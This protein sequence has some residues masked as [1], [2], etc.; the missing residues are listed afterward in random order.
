M[1]I[2]KIKPGSE[3]S[4][5]ALRVGAKISFLE[6]KDYQT[7]AVFFKELVLYS[8]QEKERIDAQKKLGEI[9]FERL[10]DNARAIDE[11]NKVLLIPIEPEEET[12]LR[13]MLAKAYFYLN[14]FGQAESEADIILEKAKQ[15]KS[16]FDAKLVK[17]N[18]AFSTQK[19]DRSAEIYE[20]LM[21]EFPQESREEHVGLTLAIVYEEQKELDEAIKVL[22]K[23]KTSY[24]NPE[25]IETKLQR[26]LEKKKLLPGARGLRK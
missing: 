6:A 19:F 2:A 10:S 11:L 7:A 23:I 20:K 22:E 14:K 18:V 21:S 16:I 13:L 12:K 1:A 24:P 17:A 5:D 26:I 15:P 3:E 4:L 25:F 9:Y 8:D